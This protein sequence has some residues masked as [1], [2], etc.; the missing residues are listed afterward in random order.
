MIALV[1]SSAAFLLAVLLAEVLAGRGRTQTTIGRV[2]A[3]HGGVAL[4][5]ILWAARVGVADPLPVLLFWLGAGLTWT[6]VR[7]HIESSILL[8]MTNVLAE[9]GGLSGAELL[10]CCESRYGVRVRLDELSRTGFIRRR[11]EGFELRRK[12][13][14]VVRALR[15]R[16]LAGPDAR[17]V[18]P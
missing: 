2:C 16:S 9:S 7:M 14:L 8:R 17:E 6:G 18:R 15:L 13:H 11:G 12:G 3:I 1:G 10:A 5:W 4:L